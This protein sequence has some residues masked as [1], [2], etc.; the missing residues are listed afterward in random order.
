M[1]SL[2]FASIA[3]LLDVAPM[4]CE[5]CRSRDNYDEDPYLEVST[6]T[7]VLENQGSVR[8]ISIRSNKNWIVETNCEQWL[9]V[10]PKS[11]NGNADIIVTATASSDSA[12]ERACIITIGD[13]KNRQEV[14]VKQLGR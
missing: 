13:L 12:I 11:G 2:L 14:L 8:V 3:I 1:K 5:S 6:K 4:G 7:V 9:D 10:N